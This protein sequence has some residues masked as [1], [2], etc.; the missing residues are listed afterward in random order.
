MRNAFGVV[1]L[2]LALVG[3]RAG[4][5]EDTVVVKVGQTRRMDVGELKRIALGDTQIAEVRT[6]GSAQLDVTG[7]EEGKTTLLVWKQSGER[8]SYL[9]H[10]TN[11][12]AEA[13]PA[14]KAEKAEKGTKTLG[15]PQTLRVKQGETKVLSVPNVTRVAVGDPAIADIEVGGAGS[16]RVKARGVGE[17]TLLVWT[18]EGRQEYSVRV[19]K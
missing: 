7:V 2:A 11:K 14:K 1:V 5:E 9:V 18:P 12:G 4:A 13:A 16:L 6:V 19:E 8:V 17:T 10:V 3:L 15:P